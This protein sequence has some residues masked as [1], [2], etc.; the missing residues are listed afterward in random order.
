MNRSTLRVKAR[1]TD[2]VID[3]DPQ[4]GH[5]KKGPDTLAGRGRSL[6]LW[7]SGTRGQVSRRNVISPQFNLSRSD[8]QHKIAAKF[9]VKCTC[10]KRTICSEQNGPR[11]CRG[12]SWSRLALVGIS[13][14]T[15]RKCLSNRR[16]TA[17]YR[18]SRTRTK[19]FRKLVCMHCALITIPSSPEIKLPSRIRAAV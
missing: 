19:P 15:L 5:A 9:R 13:M 12:P 1:D 6:R 4:T 18:D 17:T 7:P 3:K 16:V 8:V 11:N 10:R 2:V 14:D